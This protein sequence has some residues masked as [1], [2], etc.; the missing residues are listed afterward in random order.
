MEIL[1][2]KELATFLNLSPWTIRNWRLKAGLPYFGTAGRIFYRKEAVMAWM[3]REEE[4][5]AKMCSVSPP[6]K[7]APIL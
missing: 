1:T 6:S 3:E 4:R 5:N 7:M 2:E